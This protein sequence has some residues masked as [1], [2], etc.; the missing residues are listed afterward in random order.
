MRKIVIIAV[1]LA[2]AGG[3]IAGDHEFEDD[4]LMQNIKDTNDDLSSEISSQNVQASADDAKQLQQLFGKVEA[5]FVS[6]SGAADAVDLARKSETYASDIMKLV[7][8]NKFDDAADTATNL[9]R[10]CR[11]CHTFYK[12]E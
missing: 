2:M 4:D 10:T 7:A 3:V 8:N 5:H 9:S 6:K 11:T 1:A 12:K